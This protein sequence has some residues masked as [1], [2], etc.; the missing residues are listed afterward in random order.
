VVIARNGAFNYKKKEKHFVVHV[1]L[2]LL[3]ARLFA[4][5]TRA[6][7]LYLTSLLFVLHNPP[8]FII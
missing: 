6:V 4:L 8:A 1:L 7:L 5:R 2:W 3:K